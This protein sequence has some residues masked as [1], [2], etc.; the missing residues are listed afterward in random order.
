MLFSSLFMDSLQ[1]TPDG[2]LTKKQVARKLGVGEKSI[3]R[4]VN[5]GKIPCLR[6]SGTV[7]RFDWP[8]VVAHVKRVFGTA[9]LK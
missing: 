6:F 1:P 7:L 4:W 8:D 2:F 3:Q 5:E 9:A